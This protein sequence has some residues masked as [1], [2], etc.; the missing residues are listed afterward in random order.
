MELTETMQNKININIDIPK[1]AN[2][3]LDIGLKAILPDFIEN[4]IIEIKDA[5][6]KNGFTAGLEEARD[7]AEEIWKSVKGVF[8]GEFDSVGEIKRLIQKN[9]I[10]DTAST[11]VDKLSKTLLDKKIINKTTYN[12]IKTGKKEILN[13]LEGELKTYYK[14]D[15][16]NL[17][18]L[19]NQ[20]QSWKESY[21]NQ[22]YEAMQKESQKIIQTLQKN[23]NLEKILVQARNIEKVQN[24]ITQRGTIENLTK[25][26]K[27]ILENIN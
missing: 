21:Q 19:Q 3:A 27:K 15:E 17:E 23:E 6:I 24:Y 4:D 18:T 10:L 25:S 8:T 13:A 1:V 20:I 11:L 7:K 12:L 5:F 26:E 14:I 16:Y 2:T 9:G 22:D